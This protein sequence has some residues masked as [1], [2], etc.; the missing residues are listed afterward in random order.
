MVETGNNTAND[1]KTTQEKKWYIVFV[2]TSFE[3]KA[4]D[5]LELKISTSD[6]K[7]EFGEIL[8]PTEKVFEVSKGKKKVSQRKFFP[9]YLLVNMIMTEENWHF[10]KSTPRIVGFVGNSQHPPFLNDKEINRISSQ[11]TEEE[12]SKPVPK[13]I[14]V[15]G[16]AVRVIDGPFINFNGQVDDVNIDK[17]KLRVLVSIFGRSTPV[18]LDFTQVE[19]I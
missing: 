6:K 18:E 19:K 16:E 10:V 4:K 13:V 17:A 14:Y 9:G 5:Q 8:I 15:V 12:T 3:Q 1:K 11:V 7:E 2:R